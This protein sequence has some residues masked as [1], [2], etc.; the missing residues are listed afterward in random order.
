[1]PIGD[2]PVQ[3]TGIGVTYNEARRLRE[4]LNSLSFCDQLIVVDLGSEDESVEIARECG[5]EIV[6]HERVPVVE[7]VWPDAVPLARY[8]WVL[9]ADPDEVFPAPLA[10]DLIYTIAEKRLAGMISLP[11]Q[12]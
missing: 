1:M 12:Y 10:S 6:H 9:R 5:A 7:Q 11:Q 3:F 2:N 4:C 8:K